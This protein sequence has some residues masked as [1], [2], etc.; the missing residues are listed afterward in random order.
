VDKICKP[1]W[2]LISNLQLSHTGLSSK[3]K[4]KTLDGSK[5]VGTAEAVHAVDGSRAVGTAEAVHA[6]DGS[7]AVEAVDA[8]DGKK[9]KK[10]G[11]R[12]AKVTVY[13][14]MESVPVKTPKLT[15][16]DVILNADVGLL[17]KLL[18]V[19]NSVHGF[20]RIFCV[21]KEVNDKQDPRKLK[22]YIHFTKAMG[23]DALF[24]SEEDLRKA[25]L[26][27]VEAVKHYKNATPFAEMPLNEALSKKHFDQVFIEAKPEFRKPFI[28]TR[29]HPKNLFES[30]SRFARA[31][32]GGPAE[33][34][35]ENLLRSFHQLMQ[36]V[37]ESGL[38][39]I[40]NKSV[41]TDEQ[42]KL[43]HEIAEHSAVK[44]SGL[45]TTK[46]LESNRVI[47]ISEGGKTFIVLPLKQDE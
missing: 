36:G 26:H 5:A 23:C 15:R 46:F 29:A 38:P 2:N 10:D 47:R 37:R 27:I 4:S 45:S 39:L 24:P 19:L 28:F 20:T 35:I 3:S 43:F 34:N 18:D 42:Y 1:F 9:L 16:T 31:A 41:R 13:P 17:L 30:E 8:V 40:G 7:R 12:F 14:D 25:L 11:P 32:A 44:D 21:F 6:V 22:Q 33:R